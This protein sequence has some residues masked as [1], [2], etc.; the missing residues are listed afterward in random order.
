MQETVK[1]LRGIRGAEMN[2]D[3]WFQNHDP[4]VG[5]TE[6]EA[7]CTLVTYKSRTPLQPPPS[8]ITTKT[9]YEALTDKDTHE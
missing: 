7:P 8:S 2:I 9:R 6:N 4:V 5:T 1:R 3:K